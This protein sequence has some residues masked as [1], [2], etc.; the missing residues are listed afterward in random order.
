MSTKIENHCF[1]KDGNVGIDKQIIR[2]A[3]NNDTWGEVDKTQLLTFETV[4][5][6]FDKKDNCDWF[7]RMSTGGDEDS[8]CIEKFWSIEGPEELIG[9]FNELARR[10]GMRCRWKCEK[11]YVEPSADIIVEP[12]KDEKK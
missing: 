4:S 8:E 3:Q 11:F 6:S 5:V 9:L 7:F 2:F 10:T 12:K 1:P